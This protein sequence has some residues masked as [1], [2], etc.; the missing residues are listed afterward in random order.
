VE[1]GEGFD[2]L[3]G[4]RLATFDDD[5]GVGII[6]RRL[7]SPHPRAGG[8]GIEKVPDFDPGSEIGL[9]TMEK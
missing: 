8:E 6:G 7:Q 9:I 5:T 2:L 3:I 4:I 1:F